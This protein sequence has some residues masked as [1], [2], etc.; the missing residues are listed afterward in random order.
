MESGGTGYTRSMAATFFDPY[1]S[2]LQRQLQ[3]QLTTGTADLQLDRS[4]TLE[5]INLMRPYIERRF[6]QQMGAKAADVAGRGF[7]GDKS[8]IMRS[9]LGELG[10]EHAFARGQVERRGARELTDIDRAI[11]ALTSGTT[12]SGAEGVRQGAGRATNR[13]I[14]QLPF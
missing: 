6:Q 1:L 7:A 11:A 2:E 5:D 4:R 12:R 3:H 13:A 9:Q 8:G 10:E 14:D